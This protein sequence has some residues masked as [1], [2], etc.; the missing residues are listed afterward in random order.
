MI[1][2]VRFGDAYG[3]TMWSPGLAVALRGA[4][5]ESRSETEQQHLQETEGAKTLSEMPTGTA[6]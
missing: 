3:A 6:G 5:C 4:P 1:V 2:T